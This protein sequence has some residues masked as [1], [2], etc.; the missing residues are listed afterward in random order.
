MADKKADGSVYIDTKIDTSEIEKGV[1][2]IKVSFKE[3][4]ENANSATVEIKNAFKAL[5]DSTDE[6]SKELT[7]ILADTDQTANEKLKN[8][9]EVFEKAGVETSEAWRVAGDV[10]VGSLRKAREEAANAPLTDKISR[11][12]KELD[13]LKNAYINASH[14]FGATSDEAQRLGRKIEDL[15]T[16]LAENEA[17]MEDAA[18]AA[19]KYDKS[20]KSVEAPESGLLSMLKGGIAGVAT[21]ATLK[22]A[23]EAVVEFGKESVKLGSDLQEA[24][25]VVDVT[26][27]TMSEKVNEFAKSADTSA[28]LSE[29]MAKEYAG[30]FGT[31]AKSMG[32]AEAEAYELATAL[33]Q[34]TGDLASFRNLSQDEAFTKLQAIFTGETESLKALGVVMTQTNLD[35]FALANGFGKTTDAMTEQEKVSLRYQYVMDQLSAAQGDFVRTQDSWANQTKTLELQ[36]EN[37]KTTVGEGLTGALSGTVQFINE[38]TLPSL[39]ALAETFANMFK[40]TPADDFRAAMGDVQNAIDDANAE[41]NHMAAETELSASY[42]EAHA[43]ALEELT[44]EGLNTA[45]SMSQAKAL[46]AELNN[47]VPDL[48]LEINEQTGLLNKNT[49]EINNSIAAMKKKGM[50]EATIK[51]LTTAQQKQTQATEAQTEA[52]GR[53]RVL[54]EELRVKQELLA[55][56]T[57]GY[58]EKNNELAETLSTVNDYL[59]TGNLTVQKSSNLYGDLGAEIEQTEWEIAAL[60][61]SMSESSAV[62]QENQQIID[63]WADEAV[64]AGLEVSETMDGAA[65]STK[66]AME[67]IAGSAAAGTSGALS[68]TSDIVAGV[69]DE[70][71]LETDRTYSELTQGLENN[72]DIIRQHIENLSALMASNAP[73]SL[74]AQF[75]N[76]NSDAMAALNEAMQASNG[77]YTELISNFNEY[78]RATQELQQVISN[79]EY[80]QAKAEAAGR[81]SIEGVWAEYQQQ[82]IDWIS[83]RAKLVNTEYDKA[84]SEARALVNEAEKLADEAS[85]LYSKSYKAKE[86]GNLSLAEKYRREAAQKQSEARELLAEAQK[87]YGS[88]GAVGVIEDALEKVENAVGSMSG[89]IS[90]SVEESA[91]SISDNFEEVIRYLE[92]KT[93]ISADE[94]REIVF[95]T[96]DDAAAAAED[97]GDAVVKAS[98]DATDKIVD[99]AKKGVDKIQNYVDGLHGTTID[100]TFN[101]QTSGTV[102]SLAYSG[103]YTMPTAIPYLAEGAVI[104]PNAPFMAVLGD[105]RHGT[106]LEAPADLIR[107]I[108]REEMEGAELGGDISISF[109]G[110]LAGLASVLAPVITREQRRS[111]RAGGY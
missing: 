108:V 61:K 89:A 47:L 3:C 85:E 76:S 79:W 84:K 17:A 72:A 106:N 71:S 18:A 73:D 28:G 55:D 88:E 78:E 66:A 97:A 26:F 95:G 82:S 38:T 70:L 33:T 93:K 56:A 51:R 8:I 35:A 1:Q 100:I 48:N 111:S 29:T 36:V 69:M 87:L 27:T 58:S 25:N 5:G 62:I 13:E 94:I 104:P 45:S 75:A 21:V 42:A 22:E 24:Q 12:K 105:Q 20:L 10:I 16:E 65:E 34:F 74:I 2:N 81:K 4:A 53:L 54:K 103:G 19:D 7:K 40:A 92:Q 15:S 11:Q 68:G 9:A 57:D 59:T 109:N 44:A 50:D 101:Y 67:E 86:E 83:S 64:K 39:Q 91:N 60:E 63:E 102:P 6:L 49:K 96:R 32:F 80:E 43:S 90:D 107:Q 110:D 31:M 98:E 30:T 46:V 77:Q 41:Y 23:A 14:K 52:E 37:L 99:N